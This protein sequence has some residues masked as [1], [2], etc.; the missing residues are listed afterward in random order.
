MKDKH[1]DEHNDESTHK[2]EAQREDDLQY[3]TLTMSKEEMDA[4][5]VH[6]TCSKVTRDSSGS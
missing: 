1:N 4:Q 5:Y 6:E 2:E 3:S